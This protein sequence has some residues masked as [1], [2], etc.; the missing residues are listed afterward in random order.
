MPTAASS[1]E[2]ALL[3]LINASRAAEGLGALTMELNLNQSANDHSQWMTDT[4]TFSHTGVGNSTSRERMED[5]GLDL[6]GSWGT[7]E[8]IA[9]HPGYNSEND[10]PAAQAR[11]I[12]EAFMDSPGHRANIMNPSFTHV[13]IGIIYGPMDFGGTT[14]TAAIVTQNFAYSWG[15]M[16]E[17]IP[18]NT[19]SSAE[20]VDQSAP[21]DTSTPA[22]VSDE[23]STG[24]DQ[25]TG[26]PDAEK[27][28]GQAGN[29]TI[30]GKGGDD[31]LDGG[32]GNDF[33]KGGQGDDILRDTQGNNKMNGQK[34][35]DLIEAGAG[36]DRL[37]GGGDQDTLNAGAGDDFLKGGTSDDILNGG[38]GNDSLSGNLNDDTLNG[39][40]GNDLLKGGGD[41]DQLSG[42]AGNDTLKG[43]SGSDVFIFE[44]GHD[45]ILD[46]TPGKDVIELDDGLSSRSIAALLNGSVSQSPNGVVI[47][48]G[49]NN[50]LEIQGD[51]SLAQLEADLSFF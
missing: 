12:H 23:T 2:H 13:G 42:G 29:D 46:Y 3:E 41:A 50:S 4:T 7:A 25:I 51:F 15:E 8:N 1:F 36:D 34:G 38:T 20:T 27:I 18:G 44:S 40:A 26:T 37:N 47:D 43:G 10:S 19:P 9:A 14:A 11:A 35:N 28:T 5:A 30:D 16:D 31:T 21:N 32:A 22:E 39:G 24:N 17:D 48:F 33:L 6:S 45:V 49:G